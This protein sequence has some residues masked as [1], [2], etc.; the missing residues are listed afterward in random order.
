[1]PAQQTNKRLL[2]VLCALIAIISFTWGVLSTQ[3]KFF[4]FNQLTK[5]KERIIKPIIIEPFQP[6]TAKTV[7][8]GDSITAGANWQKLFPEASILN[9]GISGNE[10]EDVI[11]RLDT[12]LATKPTNAFIM[13]GINDIRHGKPYERILNNYIEII[14]TLQSNKVTPIIQSTLY[15]TN[16]FPEALINLGY[17]ASEFPKS[18]QVNIEVQKLNGD[19]SDYA[20]KNN[21]VFINLNEVLSKPSKSETLRCAVTADGVHLNLDGHQV[22]KNALEKFI[23]H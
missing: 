3:Y 21:I 2:V 15:V 1:M 16:D 13:I 23:N 11:K 7:M 8:I 17:P 10:T 9:R 18:E 19:L 12:I 14:K 22:W 5:I 20:N 6:S 4:P